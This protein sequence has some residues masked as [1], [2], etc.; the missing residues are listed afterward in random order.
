VTARDDTGQDSTGK[1]LPPNPPP[2]ERPGENEHESGTVSRKYTKFAL[3]QHLQTPEVLAAVR[4]YEDHCNDGGSRLTRT[5]RLHAEELLNAC[6]TPAEAVAIIRQTTANPK[7]FKLEPLRKETTRHDGRS[8][9]AR[10]RELCHVPV[11]PGKYAGREDDFADLKARVGTGDFDP[12]VDGD[13]GAAGVPVGAAAG[14]CD[15]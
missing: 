1:K 10:S 11:P 4:A 15:Y 8:Q 5:V 13:L 14:Q 6:Q 3:A 12:A 9:A 2:G 7:W